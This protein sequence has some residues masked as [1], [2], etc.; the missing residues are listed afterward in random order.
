MAAADVGTLALVGAGEYLPEMEPVDRLL[1]DHVRGSLR[2]V[3]LPTAAVPDGRRVAE[4]R[5]EM[6]VAHFTRLGVYVEAAMVLTRA[7]ADS[8]ALAAQI[9]EASFV[10]LSGGKPTYL[11]QTLR[12]SACWRAIA[13]VY[14]RG[15]VVAGC[16][17]GAMVLGGRMFAG[18]RFWRSV[19]GLGLAGELAVIPRADELPR[20]LTRLAVRSAGRVP[21]AAV[22][23]GTALIST[24]GEW[25]VAGSGGVTIYGTGRAERYTASQRVRL[26]EA[27]HG[28]EP[29]LEAHREIK[30]RERRGVS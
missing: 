5:A 28:H 23:G 1:L 14:A 6:G 11:L 22:D 13:S 29:V 21:V 4:R 20:W 18:R 10:Y 17:A 26:M 2:V 12:E 25:L 24:G 19:P 27:G 8:P 7:D 9:G 3:V 15:G 16:S 30:G